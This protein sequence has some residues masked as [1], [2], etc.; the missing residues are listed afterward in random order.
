[1]TTENAQT[2]ISQFRRHFAG[3][4]VL[5]LFFVSHNISSVFYQIRNVDGAHYQGSVIGYFCGIAVSA[6]LIGHICALR[7]GGA[8]SRAASHAGL[9]FITL[10]PALISLASPFLLTEGYAGNALINTLQPGLW[11]MQLPLALYLFFRYTPPLQQAFYYCLTL[12]AGHLCW[13]LLIPLA[14]MGALVGAADFLETRYLPFLNAA[15]FMTSLAFTWLVFTLMPNRRKDAPF[16][17]D[18]AGEHAPADAAVAGQGSALMPDGPAAADA[19]GPPDAPDAPPFTGA[20]RSGLLYLL[21]PLLICFFYNGVQGYLFFPR[22]VTRGL[23]AEYLHL[24]L[25]VL[26][27]VLGFFLRGGSRTDA[28]QRPGAT[29]AKDDGQ[30]DKRQQRL[31][32][33]LIIAVILCF[34]VAPVLLTRLPHGAAFQTMYFICAVCLQVL[35]MAGTLVCGRYATTSRRPA[36]VTSGAWLAG[37]AAVAGNAAAT[38]LF[39]LLPVSSFSAIIFLCLACVLSLPLLRRAFPLPESRKIHKENNEEEKNA[40]I[41]PSPESEP[42]QVYDRGADGPEERLAAYAQTHRLSRREREIALLLTRGKTTDQI[43]EILELKITS[44]RHY[45]YTLLKKPAPAAGWRLLPPSWATLKKMT[46]QEKMRH[47]NSLILYNNINLIPQHCA[48]FRTR[49]GPFQPSAYIAY[50]AAFCFILDE[51]RRW[52]A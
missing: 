13:S 28:K 24:V 35:F 17:D 36:L 4:L 25:A 29:P 47:R 23:Y 46:A 3:F 9:L 51:A 20:R 37:G 41:T 50:R 19:P 27:P 5:A 31:L 45:I 42:M 2:L 10:L 49:K 16:P 7:S 11:A 52:F 1:M 30:E 14:H 15:R 32:R 43:A 6:L 48:V 39:P 22:L 33:R 34:A 21:V 38:R 12:C 26:F 40:S 8:F 18:A 44:V